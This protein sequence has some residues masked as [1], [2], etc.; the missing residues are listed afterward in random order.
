MKVLYSE[1]M[2]PI[3]SDCWLRP[4]SLIIEAVEKL[5]KHRFDALPVVDGNGVLIG[6]FSKRS[7]YKCLIKGVGLGDK[8]EGHYVNRVISIFCNERLD[9]I[10]EIRHT[11]VGQWVIV[12]EN[13]RPAG[14]LTKINIVLFLLNNTERLMTELT[15]ILNA[16]P[17]GVIAVDSQGKVRLFNPAAEEMLE[18]PAGTVVEKPLEEVMQDFSLEKVLL[19]GKIKLREKRHLDN[20]T[21][22]FGGHPVRGE[23]DRINGAIG[24]VQDLTEF[25]NMSQ[26]L[27]SVRRLQQTLETILSSVDNGIV[28]TDEKGVIVRVNRAAVSLLKKTPE[29]VL[30]KDFKFILNSRI[31]DLV[32]LK[33]VSG[34]DVGNIN[35]EGFLMTSNPVL[36][37]NAVVGTVTSL[38]YK[39]LA[40]LKELVARLDVLESQLKYYKKELLKVTTSRYNFDSIVTRSK[41][42]LKLK[43]E[44]LAAAAGFSNILLLGESGTGK[45]LF[46]HAIHDASARR[47]A[48][49]IKVNCAAIPENLL[50]SELFGYADGAFTGA[51]KGGKPGKFELAHGGTIFLDEIGDMQHPLQ[52]KILRVIQEREFERV[53]G[54]RTIQVDVRIIAATN[55]NIQEMIGKNQFRQD[56]YYRLNVIQ[57]LMAPLRERREDII[58][59]AEHYVKLFN[60]SMGTKVKGFNAEARLIMEN[61]D[62]PGNV[63]EIANVVERAMNMNV[64]DL[65]GLEHLPPYLV[66]KTLHKDSGLKITTPGNNGANYRKAMEVYERSLMVAALKDVGGNCKEAARLLG[67]SRSRFYEKVAL[68]SIKVSKK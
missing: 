15:A 53:G 45:E 3:N 9:P 20:R 17:I 14:M 49:F 25:E 32:L 42:M 2:S 4:D 19:T 36:E 23:N 33:G 54:T 34:A 55:K 43:Q 60:E 61:Y 12:D 40:K 62:W 46:A 56:L 51:Q 66:D 16:I 13:N 28:V 35:G 26:E 38:I 10:S 8:I 6:V 41:A 31:V 59:L 30:G 22:I 5:Q 1:V 64:K 39:N 27:E 67:M 7:L 48:P 50:E 65:I 47:M 68:Y 57:L 21:V 18:K 58:Y 11:P 52:A 24:I 37:S 63:R 44:A 29:E